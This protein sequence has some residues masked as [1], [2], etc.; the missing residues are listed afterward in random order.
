MALFNISRPSFSS[1]WH[2]STRISGQKDLTG[3][4]YTRDI[5][6]LGLSYRRGKKIKYQIIRS[7]GDA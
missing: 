1:K 5:L 2:C 4:A 3:P 7:V 6:Q